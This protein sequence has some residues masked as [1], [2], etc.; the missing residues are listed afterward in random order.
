MTP[1]NLMIQSTSVEMLQAIISRGGADDMSLKEIEAVVIGKLYIS[2]HRQRLDVQPRLLHLLYSVLSATSAQDV[3]P[4]DSEGKRQSAPG[5]LTK[6]LIDGV[7][8]PTNRP[9][10]QH[11]FD[12]I[13]MSM[14]KP[15]FN[16]MPSVPTIIDHVGREIR[17]S[18]AGTAEAFEAANGFVDA[19]TAASEVEFVMY[20]NALESLVLASLGDSR[21]RFASEEAAAIDRS[22]SESGGLF[23]FFTSDAGAPP[24]EEPLVVSRLD[25]AQLISVADQ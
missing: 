21:A 24:A 7:T 3:A 11:W 25:Q 15:Q 19:K 14:P 16:L 17:R 9:I 1:F 5:F 20:L 10:F 23:S 18:L 22:A 13:T 6:V 12:F 8:M 4:D 2:I